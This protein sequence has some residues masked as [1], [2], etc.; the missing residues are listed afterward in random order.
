MARRTVTLVPNLEKEVRAV[1]AR[2]LVLWQQDVS[3]TEALNWCLAYGFS[4]WYTADVNQEKLKEVG[5]ENIDDLAAMYR[6][7]AD[8]T[9]DAQRDV[10]LQAMVESI[11]QSLP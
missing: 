7:D 6:S 3:F 4:Y 1:Q 11:G 8:L 5:A 9:F 10:Q 2:M